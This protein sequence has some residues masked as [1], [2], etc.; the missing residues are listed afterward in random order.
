MTLKRQISYYALL[1]IILLAGCQKNDG[2][3]DQANN[4]DMLCFSASLEGNSIAADRAQTRG[5]T[6][7]VSFETRGFTVAAYQTTGPFTADGSVELPF[8]NVLDW[9]NVGV[10]KPVI[11]ITKDPAEENPKRSYK[12]SLPKM[13]RTEESKLSFFAWS[14][15]F[16][17]VITNS[18]QNRSDKGAPWIDVTLNSAD[19]NQ[20]D[21]V[22]ASSV[23][24]DNTYI[25]TAV[26]LDFQH[27]LSKMTFNIKTSS[28]VVAKIT[29]VSCTYG[30]SICSKGR[31]TFNT[32]KLGTWSDLTA[33]YPSTPH[34]INN[35]T[36]PT[37]LA[38]PS[39]L[40]SM[41][42][43]PQSLE[44]GDVT[45]NIEYTIT[46]GGAT[47][48]TVSRSLPLKSLV[49][50]AGQNYIYT[51]D[52]K[53]NDIVLSN[54]RVEGWK[55]LSGTELGMPLVPGPMD[56]DVLL[57]LQGTD[58]PYVTADG[59]KFWLDR[60][61]WNNHCEIMDKSQYSGTN[62][63]DITYD[64]ANKG[65]VFPAISFT[66]GHILYN[67]IRIP[68]LGSVDGNISFEMVCHQTE[69][70][71]GD[72]Y[73]FTLSQVD[74]IAYGVSVVDN[75]LLRPD[76]AYNTS[77]LQWRYGNGE[78]INI[79]IGAF[80]HDK[81]S[82]YFG[83]RSTS[84]N[85]LTMG[86]GTTN[87]GA[88]SIST[89]YNGTKS[90][91][92]GY[93]GPRFAGTINYL[94][95]IKKA[96]TYDEVLNDYQKVVRYYNIVE[97]SVLA[98]KLDGLLACWDA[99]S[100]LVGGAADGNNGF[101]MD[102]SGNG[103]YLKAQVPQATTIKASIAYNAARKALVL[104]GPTYNTSSTDKGVALIN[105]ISM[106]KTRVL[107]FEL[108]Y[109]GNGGDLSY[110]MQILDKLGGK[111][112]INCRT[113][114]GSTQNNTELRHCLNS[115]TVANRFQSRTA[116]QAKVRQHMVGTINYDNQTIS[117]YVN[118]VKQEINGSYTAPNSPTAMMD[119]GYTVLGNKGDS[120]LRGPFSQAF[121]GDIHAFRVYDRELTQ[122]E[123]TANYNKDK[124]DF[125]LP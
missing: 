101:W 52:L 117:Y 106:G 89:S 88:G 55:E 44:D 21:I 81:R 82:Y 123:I 62:S 15:S 94:K 84:T 70:A 109:Q 30:E 74:P 2:G 98:P 51:L 107:T 11:P 53:A 97:E 34:K 38:T 23:N 93:I 108:V 116:E 115:V 43:I 22:A 20:A 46:Q 99:R 111:D 61:G 12:T 124:T 48:P 104:S 60:S 103:Y 110:A 13:A 28:G 27:V 25:V 114:T 35:W 71:S 87:L 86:I 105:P 14:S 59:R 91:K 102:Q 26:D 72:P 96:L 92:C 6:G 29:S 119:L 112:Y 18:T 40:G 100:G 54:V 118:G 45:I 95:I 41:T 58:A 65:Y 64:P 10:N 113:F 24:I 1:I 3:V 7:D 76:L 19:K 37:V 5:Y 90:I 9:Q 73:G 77:T 31:F 68:D 42:F 121:T 66:N 47:S 4:S 69:T 50:E 32:D 17:G 56:P 80:N 67:H 79:N 122:A 36:S 57:I 78:L 39:L 16:D 83:T 8:P 125:N 75:H 85:Q 63:F 33:P 49:M 120:D